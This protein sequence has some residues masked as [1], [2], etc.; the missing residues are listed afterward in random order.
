MRGLDPRIHQ[1]RSF[2]CKAM[3]CRDKPG[4]DQRSVNICEGWY[5]SHALTML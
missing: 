1:K 5:K 4:N 2:L 3:D